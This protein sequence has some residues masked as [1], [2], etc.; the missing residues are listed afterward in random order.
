MTVVVTGGTTGPLADRSRTEM[1]ELIA[2]AGE[3]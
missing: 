2:R 1:T 3:W